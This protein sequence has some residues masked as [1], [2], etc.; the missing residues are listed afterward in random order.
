[1]HLGTAVLAAVGG[2]A[3]FARTRACPPADRTPVGDEQRASGDELPRHALPPQCARPRGGDPV[4]VCVEGQ[5]P[6]T[7][8]A[9]TRL[10][11]PGLSRL[12]RTMAQCPLRRGPPHRE[13]GEQKGDGPRIG[14]SPRGRS[15]GPSGALRSAA[16]GSDGTRTRGLR[17]ERASQRSPECPSVRKD[18]ACAGSQD[19]PRSHG[20]HPHVPRAFRKRGSARRGHEPAAPAWRTPGPARSSWV[21]AG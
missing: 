1:M 8:T 14:P 16:N 19:P 5:K 3:P 11:Y 17:R 4:I 9:P 15:A 6:A 13:R 12:V 7:S 18:N 2:T 10:D 21:A 20:E